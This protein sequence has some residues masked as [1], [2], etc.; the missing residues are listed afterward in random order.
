MTLIL[1]RQR[2]RMNSMLAMSPSILIH[3]PAGGDSIW[4]RQDAVSTVS[5]TLSSDGKTM[6]LLKSRIAPRNCSLCDGTKD[7]FLKLT[8]KPRF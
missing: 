4:R 2:G 6:P 5:D 7:D 3:R 8:I 1:M